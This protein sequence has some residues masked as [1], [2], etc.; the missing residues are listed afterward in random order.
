MAQITT[1][2]TSS[3]GGGISGSGAA[4]RIAYW[5]GAS[6][7]TS[8]SE[9]FYDPTNNRVSI[10][11]GTLPSASLTIKTEGITD[12]SS[13]IHVYTQPSEAITDVFRVY[14]NGR[15]DSSVCRSDDGTLTNTVAIGVNAGDSIATASECVFLGSGAGRFSVSNIGCTAT[16]N[17]AFYVGTGNYNDA[18]GSNSLRNC[19]NG[20]GNSGFGSS[21]L[22]TLTTGT[23]SCAL[24]ETAGRYRRP[25][26]TDEP[27]NPT[28]GVYI[29]SGSRSGSSTT[30]VTNEIVIGKGAIGAGGN[31]TTIGNSSCVSCFISG[32]VVPELGMTIPDGTNITFDDGTGTKI[33]TNAAE[34]F[35]FWN[36][37][38]IAQPT[39]SIPG[40]TADHIVGGT[41][42]KTSDT[43]D[44]YTVGQVVAALRA[45]GILA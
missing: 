1:Y 25:G 42:I 26:A 33:G 30:N 44:N 27:V 36:K 9:L 34:K 31:T 24:G 40:I 14:S 23:Y 2:F 39:T 29:G 43:F 6:S 5:S 17:N 8:D 13:A 19:T 16:G 32:N 10:S 37:T 41:N 11:A 15:I 35:A 21:T 7:I 45:V 3:S 22:E 18:Y 4:T 38:P 28:D 20:T 12:A